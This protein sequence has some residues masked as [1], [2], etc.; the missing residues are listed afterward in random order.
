MSF[1]ETHDKI[2]ERAL[3]ACMEVREFGPLS[4]YRRLATECV[5]EPE[6]MAQVLMCLAAWVDV[7][8]PTSALVERAEAITRGRVER[9]NA[10]VTA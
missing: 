5:R 2:A 1:Y 10:Q 3:R 7:E 6:R 4:V 9:K 8:S